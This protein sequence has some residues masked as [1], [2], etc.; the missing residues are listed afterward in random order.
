MSY[1]QSFYHIIFSTKNRRP[2]LKEELREEIFKYIWGISKN[3]KCHLIRINGMNEHIHILV[4]LHS[5]VSLSSYVRDVKTSTS[6]WLK[7]HG[8]IKDFPGWQREY[9]ALSKNQSD[10]ESVIHY[11]KNQQEHHKLITW[12]D[13]FK[14][15]L[16]KSKIKFDNKYLP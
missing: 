3:K 9:A 4:N 7:S 6:H 1:T 15:I 2:C 5:E 14:Q 12:E 16:E 10:L 13:E 8:L 11:I